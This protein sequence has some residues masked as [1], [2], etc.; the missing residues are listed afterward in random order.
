MPNRDYTNEKNRLLDSV[1]EE[2]RASQP[3]FLEPQNTE[4]IEPE[5]PELEAP[6][7]EIVV[8]NSSDPFFLNGYPDSMPSDVAPTEII[9]YGAGHEGRNS[10]IQEMLKVRYE[11]QMRAMRA[12]Y[13]RL[14]GNRELEIRRCVAQLTSELDTLQTAKK[15]LEEKI[16]QQ[17]KEVD[18]L[19]EKHLL[20]KQRNEELATLVKDY[21][22]K[23]KV[24]SD[25]LDI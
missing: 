17:N 20:L 3:E 24:M 13:T 19:L 22:E 11:E 25:N 1:M 6:P 4:N 21:E 9:D 15:R 16:A 18:E 10:A 5:S 7:S 14:V 12:A 2:I 8:E 23:N